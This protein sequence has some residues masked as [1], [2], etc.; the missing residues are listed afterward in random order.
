MRSFTEYYD[1]REA[2]RW[3]SETDLFC[4]IGDYIFRIYF[5][6]QNPEHGRPEDV[7]SVNFTQYTK[8]EKGAESGIAVFGKYYSPK[9]LKPVGMQELL[10][11]FQA[12][13]QGIKDFAQRHEKKT[14]TPPRFV[15]H[16]EDWATGEFDP[17]KFTVYKQLLNRSGLKRFGY[18]TEVD[19][20]DIWLNPL[21]PIRAAG[22]LM[23]VGA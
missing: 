12:V 21:S 2:C 17:Q 19:G 7:F 16:P 8:N 4:E 15:I 10:E 5:W 9:K 20:E 13:E 1:L 14:G 11:L 18:E 23:A 22:S 6:D 3:E